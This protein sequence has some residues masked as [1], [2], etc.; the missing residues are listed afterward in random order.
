MSAILKL[1]GGYSQI[2]G[3]DISPIPWVSAS[4]LLTKVIQRKVAINRL[5]HRPNLAFGHFG[6]D[7]ASNHF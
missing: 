4:L 6:P 3:R 2:I 5:V 7:L 1:L